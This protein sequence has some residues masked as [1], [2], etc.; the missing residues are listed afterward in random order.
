MFYQIVLY[1]LYALGFVLFCRFAL[2]VRHVKVEDAD[3]WI[4]MFKN[5]PMEKKLIQ[6]LADQE[7]KKL[8][9]Q[10]SKDRES[11]RRLECFSKR[12]E[13]CDSF[14]DAVT[15]IFNMLV[16]KVTVDDFQKIRA[17][18]WGIRQKLF[19][20]KEP[21]LFPSEAYE[22]FSMTAIIDKLYVLLQE[23]S[24]ARGKAK[25]G[26][27]DKFRALQNSLY[28]YDLPC[29]WGKYGEDCEREERIREM[30]EIREEKYFASQEKE[31]RMWGH[32]GTDLATF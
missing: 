14:S 16:E 17:V 18:V 21:I 26:L 10:L 13:I 4:V 22:I 8:V 32:N 3:R 7:A 19:D 27:M 15:A 9:D 5:S 24:D 11:Q 1:M 31:V 25:K 12:A 29:L 6:K 23:I 2:R 28:E 30:E 20:E